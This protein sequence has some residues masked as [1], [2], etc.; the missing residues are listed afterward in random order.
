MATQWRVDK[1]M[2]SLPSQL[3]ADGYT[4]RPATTTRIFTPVLFGRGITSTGERSGSFAVTPMIGGVF[5]RTNG[6]APGCEASIAW[7]LLSISLS[8]EYLFDTTS[9]SG[10][11]YYAW[12]QLSFQPLHW[13]QFGAVAERTKVNL[14]HPVLRGGFFVGLSHK[15]YEFTTYVFNPGGAGTTVV[16]EAGAS[17]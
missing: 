12:P 17:F 8:N 3:T 4:L 6:I 5:G 9:K 10:N 15:H 1:A 16:L 13:L 7:K 11:S 14:A 2:P